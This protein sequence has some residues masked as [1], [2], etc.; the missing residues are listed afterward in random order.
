MTELAYPSPKMAQKAERDREERLKIEQAIKRKL[1]DISAIKERL[2]T[3]R[4]DDSQTR[5]E[6]K[7]N[8]ENH[9]QE[10][11]RLE[12][13]LDFLRDQARTSF[14]QSLKL[15]EIGLERA[16]ATSLKTSGPTSPTIGSSKPADFEDLSLK[17]MRTQSTATLDNQTPAER[18]HSLFRMFQEWRHNTTLAEAQHIV[19]RKGD[20]KQL[21]REEVAKL[22]AAIYNLQ[23]KKK[24]SASDEALLHQLT[25]KLKMLHS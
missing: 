24:L 16:W 11:K 21:K 8:V 3:L 13:G 19:Q 1:K 6:M 4:Y 17:M 12:A 10:L 2:Y 7:M 22:R 20:V 25:H 15:E 14:L 23:Q 18:W 9:L 5:E